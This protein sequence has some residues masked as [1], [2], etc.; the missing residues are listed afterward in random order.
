[1]VAT[2]TTTSSSVPLAYFS[3][4]NPDDPV[5][6]AGMFLR[7]VEY[8][9]W[10][11]NLPALEADSDSE[12]MKLS[13]K[14]AKTA[15]QV[16]KNVMGVL[17]LE[18]LPK[19]KQLQDSKALLDMASLVAIDEVMSKLGHPTR[20]VVEEIDEKLSRWFVPK[21]PNQV[22]PTASQIR[23]RVR[24]IAKVLDDSVAFRDTRKKNR[25]SILTRGQR[26]FLELEV[27]STVG[28]VIHELIKETASNHEVS[29]ADAMVLL[30]SGTVEPEV[31]KVVV[32]TYK[33]SD[34]EGAPVF[35]QGHGWRGED[36][37]AAKVVE[38]DLS[39]VP[40]A[41]DSY[42]PS[43]FVRKYVEGRDGTC[44]AGGCDVP[45]WMCQVDHRINYAEGGPTH[46]DNLVCL[47]QR[48]HNM[49]TEGRA[50]YVLDPV[51]GDVVW[52]LAD[53]S[54][55][56][57][58]ATGPLAPSMRRWARTIAEDVM[59]HRAKMHEDARALK[60]ELENGEIVEVFDMTDPADRDNTTGSDIPF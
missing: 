48:H 11:H 47:C 5:C 59:A 16:A 42:R 31:G 50:F 55:V 36:I 25:Y 58:R 29:M 53:G 49:K 14:T 54:W 2:T 45:A 23:R 12:V 60:V 56:T 22:F 27:D 8:E 30:L 24:D 33:A 34:V 38:R 13:V 19:V 7:R 46:P 9:F 26:A 41:S 3:H 35:V 37:P 21:R 15:R 40:K 6:V 52:V 32:H 39:Q 28:V 20:A 4:S 10:L 51:T 57:T 43:D 17:R 1:M 18:E 44:R